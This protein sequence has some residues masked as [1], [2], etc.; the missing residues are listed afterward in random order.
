MKERDTMPP[1]IPTTDAAEA[2]RACNTLRGFRGT[3]WLHLTDAQKKKHDEALATA[4][5][6]REAFPWVGEVLTELGH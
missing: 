1:T 2:R 6:H 5:R 3:V 4:K